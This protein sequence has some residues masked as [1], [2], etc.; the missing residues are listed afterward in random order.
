MATYRIEWIKKS[1]E[2][3]IMVTDV[4]ANDSCEAI[5]MLKDSMPMIIEVLSCEPSG[6]DFYGCF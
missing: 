4:F 5:S 2:S 6:G 3:K 1:N